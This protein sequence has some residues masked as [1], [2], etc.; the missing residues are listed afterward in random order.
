MS[1]NAIARKVGLA[2]SS[3]ARWR[4]GETKPKAEVRRM[5]LTEY[6][7]AVELWENNLP[8]GSTMKLP[9]LARGTKT[10]AQIAQIEKENAE[11]R[12]ASEEH[13]DVTKP[14]KRAAKPKN[15]YPVAPPDGAPII[16]HM[17]YSLKCVRVDLRKPDATA[18]EKSKLRADEARTLNYLAKMEREEELREDKYVKNH[19]YFLAH[20]EKILRALRP[21]PKASKAVVKVLKEK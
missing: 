20:C 13:D 5:L 21:F 19:P 18:S 11:A 2:A 17:R 16:E 1:A 14:K 8:K 9:K 12:A 10:P 4:N 15:P 7:I 6:G 3:V